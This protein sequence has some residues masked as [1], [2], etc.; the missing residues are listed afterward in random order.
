MKEER[1]R[2]IIARI[3]AAESGAQEVGPRAHSGPLSKGLSLSNPNLPPL[4]PVNGV[5]PFLVWFSFSTVLNSAISHFRTLL[6]ELQ[7]AGRMTIHGALLP[8]FLLNT[9][10]RSSV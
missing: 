9:G 10:R 4:R 2:S 5:H 1:E 8:C 3:S 6:H 7:G